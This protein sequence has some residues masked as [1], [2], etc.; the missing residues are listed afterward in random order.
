[1]KLLFVGQTML[2]PM[3]ETLLDWTEKDISIFYS[4]AGV[5]VRIIIHTCM[6]PR[7][8]APHDILMFFSQ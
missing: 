3:A 2:V 7:S 5:E 8:Q 4:C 6:Q 1:M